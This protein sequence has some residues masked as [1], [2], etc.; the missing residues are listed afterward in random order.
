M[1]ETVVERVAWAVAETKETEPEDLDMCL[2]DHID[3]DAIR[4]LMNY[5][6]TSWQLQFETDDHVILVRGDGIVRVDG[7]RWQLLSEQNYEQWRCSGQ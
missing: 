2:R 4:N 6:N 5:E 3:P 7:G 1:T